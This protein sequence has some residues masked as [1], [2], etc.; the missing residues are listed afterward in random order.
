MGPMGKDQRGVR[1]LFRHQTAAPRATRRPPGQAGTQGEWASSFLAL[2]WG[3]AR[4]AVPGGQRPLT[5]RRGTTA[6]GIKCWEEAPWWRRPFSG[7]AVSPRWTRCQ[8]TQ[9]RAA[10]HVTATWQH[11]RAA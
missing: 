5:W 9:S 4:R 2:P 8:H 10:G 7:G 11:R 6:L 3:E 1:L